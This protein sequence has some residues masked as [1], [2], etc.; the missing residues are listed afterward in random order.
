[1]ALFRLIQAHFGGDNTDALYVPADLA[2]DFALA[3]AAFA[4]EN[5][6]HEVTIPAILGL[7]T[8]GPQDFE[9]SLGKECQLI[10]CLDFRSRVCVHAHL[11]P[12]IS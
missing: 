10:S 9:V 3:S 8:E 6:P 12:I 5:L 11:R 2:M 7:I 1:M 4:Q